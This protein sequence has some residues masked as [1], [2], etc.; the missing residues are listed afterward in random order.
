MDILSEL[1]FH[2]DDDDN[3]DDMMTVDAYAQMTF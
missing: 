1:N 3:A 2:Y